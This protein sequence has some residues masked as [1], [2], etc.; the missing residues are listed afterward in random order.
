MFIIHYISTTEYYN[1]LIADVGSS[2]LT[3]FC[4]F[5]I[6][7]PRT[8]FEMNMRSFKVAFKYA[9]VLRIYKLSF[10]SCY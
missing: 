10:Y 2:M 1:D 3:K 8:S 7:M 9:N 6:I 5:C 4:V